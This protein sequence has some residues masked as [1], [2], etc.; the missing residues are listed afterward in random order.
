MIGRNGRLA[1]K[2]VVKGYKLEKE[3]ARTTAVLAQRLS[4]REDV[5]RERVPHGMN[6]P[7]GAFAP[8]ALAPVPPLGQGTESVVRPSSLI[9]SATVKERL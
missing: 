7:S 4:H 2:L 5:S 3:P 9:R 6:G 1:V 8:T